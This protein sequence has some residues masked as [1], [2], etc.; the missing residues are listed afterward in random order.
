MPNEKTLT[1][2]DWLEA[3][4]ELLRARGIAAVQVTTL[5]KKLRVSRGSFYWHFENHDDLLQAM[6]EWWDRELTDTVIAFSRG[7]GRGAKR[8]L[9]AIAEDVIRSNR[10]RYETAVRTWAETDKRA[11]RILRRV[12]RKR[13]E[14]VNRIL[15]EEG[16]S[17]AEARARAD[18]FVVY[19]MSEHSI[20]TQESM[21]SRLRLMRRQIRL[22]IS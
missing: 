5:A 18:L 4:M 21:E 6:L 2:D 15:L 16:L 10:N 22:L 19:I 17:P 9:E 13:L 3:A 7:R 8:R 12:V 11:A 14:Y 1:R 20:L